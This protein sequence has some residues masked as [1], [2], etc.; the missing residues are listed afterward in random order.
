MAPPLAPDVLPA[1][2]A[3]SQV[4]R[5]VKTHTCFS[6]GL[7]GQGRKELI[8]GGKEVKPTCASVSLWLSRSCLKFPREQATG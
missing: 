6:Y 3:P 4:V 7:L 1:P 5:W 8:L 2:L